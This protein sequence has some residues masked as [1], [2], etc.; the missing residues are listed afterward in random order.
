VTEQRKAEQELMAALERA[1]AADRAKSEFLAH[2]SH[3]LRTPLNAII[4]F[5]EL[6]MLK[7]PQFPLS[8]KQEEYLRDIHNSGEHLL[9][10]INGILSL[11]KIEA[12]QTVLDEEPFEI[13]EII[14]WAFRLLVEKAS[15]SGVALRK[16]AASNLPLIHGDPRLIRQALL[17]IISNATKFSHAGGS[18]LVK[19]GR[20][21]AGGIVVAV[22]DS[23]IGMTADE[24]VVALTPFGQAESSWQRR[25]E[26]TGLGLPLAKKFIELHGGALTVESTPLKGTAVT[27]TLPPARCLEDALRQH[28]PHAG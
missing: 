18:V 16:E 22:V 2:M 3:E 21:E 8:P 19:A 7:N 12:G 17:N 11:A 9:D 4:G 13:P 20:D 28:E 14:D 6:L 27:I 25:F 24:I 5:S 26:G 15:A 10:V 23:G 1:K